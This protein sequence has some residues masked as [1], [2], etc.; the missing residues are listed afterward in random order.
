MDFS[1]VDWLHAA[2]WV[3]AATV[4]V[5]AL[6]PLPVSAPLIG[7]ATALGVTVS[8]GTAGLMAGVVSVISQMKGGATAVAATK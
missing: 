3:G 6:A 2:G 7:I 1:K 5:A 4:G 8:A